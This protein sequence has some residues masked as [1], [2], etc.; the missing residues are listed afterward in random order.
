MH[1]VFVLPV[2]VK[3]KKCKNIDINVCFRVWKGQCQTSEVRKASKFRVIGDPELS[4][5]IFRGYLP[6]KDIRSV[7]ETQNMSEKV[8]RFEALEQQLELFIETTR[9]VGIIVSDVQPNGQAVLNK[10]L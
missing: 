3:N 9:Q 2:H 7:N 4:P 5:C 8:S 6:S 1:S 10:K